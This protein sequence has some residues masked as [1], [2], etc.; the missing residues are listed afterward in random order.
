MGTFFYHV[1]R[2]HLLFIHTHAHAHHTHITV[3]NLERALTIS[4][5]LF[6]FCTC[7]VT[8]SET[9]E[10]HIPLTI[11]KAFCCSSLRIRRHSTLKPKHAQCPERHALYAYTLSLVRFHFGCTRVTSPST[12]TEVFKALGATRGEHAR[13]ADK[14]GATCGCI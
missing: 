7:A 8:C 4:P 10:H 13:A 3:K 1:P 12:L 2:I 14:R 6:K 11:K 9:V 5:A